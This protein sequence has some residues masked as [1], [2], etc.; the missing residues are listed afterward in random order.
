MASTSNKTEKKVKFLVCGPVLG[1]LNVLQK[2][3]KTLQGSKAGPFDM[4]LCVGPLLPKEE[5]DGSKLESLK[6]MEFAIPVYVLEVG[7]DVSK[8]NFLIENNDEESTP[9]SPVVPLGK[10]IFYLRGGG[11]ENND[12]A[13]GGITRLPLD[14]ADDEGLDVAW[15]PSFARIEHETTAL[16]QSKVEK[17]SYKGC[18]VLLTSEWPQGL[19]NSNALQGEYQ[20]VIE[21]EHSNDLHEIGCYDVAKI[22]TL[23]K[24]RYHFAAGLSNCSYRH[25]ASLPFSTAPDSEPC[26]FIA[27]SKLST[28]KD[29]KFKFL[30]AINL[31]PLRLTE[32]LSPPDSSQL[33]TPYNSVTDIVKQPIPS[34]EPDPNACLFLYG[35]AKDISNSITGSHLLQAFQPYGCRKIH[36]P[37]KSRPS[38]AFLFFQSNSLANDC[39]NILNS[40]ITLSG[41]TL[42]LKWRTVTKRDSMPGQDQ[43]MPSK[44]R[45][46]TEEEASESTQVYVRLRNNND[47]GTEKPSFEESF[48][49]IR[50]LL[51]TSLEKAINDGNEEENN[52]VTAEEEPA[53]VVELR[54]TANPKTD[55]FAFCKFASHAAASMAIA[56]LTHSVD[57]GAIDEKHI[58]QDQPHLTGTMLYWANASSSNNNNN[59]NFTKP[60]IDSCWFCLS[61]PNVI[62]HLIISKHEHAYITIPRGPVTTYHSLIVPY[63]HHPKGMFTLPTDIITPILDM[64]RK[65][66]HYYA[67]NTTL[68]HSLFVYERAFETRG[69]LH[70]SHF[71]CI[72]FPNDLIQEL[73]VTIQAKAS[74]LGFDFEPVTDDDL[75]QRELS[76][77]FYIDLPFNVNGGKPEYK[78]LIYIPKE[79][80]NVGRRP[81]PLQFGREIISSLLGKPEL[82]SWKSCVMGED[83]EKEIAEEY[84]KKLLGEFDDVKDNDS[85]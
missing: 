53:L 74:Q 48:E 37:P 35:L 43:Q 45:R 30:H 34:F 59:M 13:G 75:I 80:N 12:C 67:E 50:K 22:A 23:T 51:Q 76:S 77:Y 38:Y 1:Q 2:K 70:H 82:S 40:E 29:P 79:G 73:D 85:K 11:G 18:D 39:L 14:C 62:Q 20:K 36:I 16:L 21:E 60:T 65:L 8:S 27:L 24:P 83:K 54:L 31:A 81:P 47:N 15:M 6:C 63:Q 71:Q 58:P 78:Q 57:G 7:T 19:A 17:D 10:N 26:R 41:I 46:M 52:K 42:S 49:E 9:S 3:L 68:N 72:P 5:N 64:K 84:R 66:Q 44:R 69:G 32:P 56:T 4:C 33:P 28:N 61:N 55:C 25:M